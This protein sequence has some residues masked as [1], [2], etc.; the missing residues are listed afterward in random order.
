MIIFKDRITLS[1]LWYAV[2]IF[3][4]SIYNINGH[5]NIRVVTCTFTG[6]AFTSRVT[7]TI[8]LPYIGVFEKEHLY[9]IARGR[10]KTHRA[11]VSQSTGFGTYYV[12]TLN[13]MI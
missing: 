10:S 13:T 11:P 8:D 7:T 6:S 2:I 3:T 5:Y 12:Y 9:T 4:V 1:K